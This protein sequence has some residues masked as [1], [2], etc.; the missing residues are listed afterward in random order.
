[1]EEVVKRVRQASIEL[2]SL[3]TEQKNQALEVYVQVLE[4]KQAQLI[5]ENQR[6]LKEQKGKI[7]PSLYQR[8]ELSA[9][10]IEV[11]IQ[12]LKDLK[13]LPDPVGK[14]TLE[15]EMKPGLNLQRVTTPIGVI[16]IIFE[17]RPDAAIQI[18]SLLLKSGNG[19]LLKGGKEAHHSNHAIA[20]IL[21]EVSRRCSFLPD[22]WLEFVETRQDVAEMLSYHQ[23][24]DLIIPRGSNELV[25]TVMNS[26]K[27]PVL[28]HADGI[29]HL[30]MDKDCDFD[31][32][33]AI[34]ANAKAQYPSACNAVETLLVHE[35]LFAKCKEA[36]AQKHP[37]IELIEAPSSWSIEYGDNRLSIKPVK[38]GVEAIEH[39]NTYGSHH[40]DGILTN[41][42]N[43]A[44]SFLKR[45]DSSSVFINCSTRL[46][47]GFQYGFGAEIGIS[48]NKTH[49]RGPVGLEGLVIYKYLVRCTGPSGSDAGLRD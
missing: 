41:D 18:S 34:V 16:G 26:T 25:Q 22:S 29:C 27:I 33:I 6:D 13:T 20:S 19:G 12:G 14:C 43:L 35:S 44:E 17:S 15:H 10:K 46:A 42:K 23:D 36:L 24:I 39:I 31:Q 21:K 11:L 28:G 8:L 49:A 30:Y 32:A 3:S 5:S 37:E 48:T 47:D 38:S 7:S 1:M 40:T 4:E 9:K 2:A 45:V